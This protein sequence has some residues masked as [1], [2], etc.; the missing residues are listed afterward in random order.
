M[1]LG[2]IFFVS[3][4]QARTCT[5]NGDVI[6]SYGF[7]GSRAGFFLLGATPPGTT[8]SGSA[9]LVPVGV[10]PPGTT[11]ALNPWSNFVNSLAGKS[12]FS[13]NGRVFADGAGNLYT[14]STP[15]ALIVNT[16]VGNYTVNTDCT[17]SMSLGNP[18][19]ATGGTIGTTLTTLVTLEGIITDGGGAGHIEAVVTGPDAAGAQV[20]FVRTSQFNACNNATIT[21]QHGV[22]GSG[23]VV[24]GTNTGTGTGAGTGV[25]SA[26]TPGAAGALGTPFTLVGRFFSDGL[27]NF[28]ADPPSVI[29]PIKRTLTGTYAVNVDCTGTG[30]FVDSSGTARNV[31]FVL[32]NDAT[33]IQ[34]S[35]Q[36][37]RF[38]FTDP[39]VIGDGSASQQ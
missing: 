26:F 33:Q 38:V 12:V 2:A 24:A 35:E 21:G 8:A 9:P 11:A 34:N 28:I 25:A 17:L 4:L 31:S 29:S 16:L 6:G 19:S 18:F 1:L 7:F 27:G 10:T 23:F 15:T 32:V 5:G 30:R 13:A 37:I 22:V 3:N 36:T 20:S 39:G 14:S